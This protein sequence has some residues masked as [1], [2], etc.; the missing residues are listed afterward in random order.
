[1]M[2]LLFWW[3]SPGLEPRVPVKQHYPQPWCHWIT[4]NQLNGGYVVTYMC[5]QDVFVVTVIFVSELGIQ[6]IKAF[7][8]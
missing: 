4:C 7:N 2:K 5:S 8:V 6:D 1:M 3:T